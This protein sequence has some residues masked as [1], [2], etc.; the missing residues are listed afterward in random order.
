MR[1]Y[2]IP[3]NYT[4]KW[5]GWLN[6]MVYTCNPSYLGG[7]GRRSASHRPAQLKLGRS[8]LKNKLKAGWGKKP[9]K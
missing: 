5:F 4:L 6:T 1:L 2:L 3:E 7:R 9:L 8:S